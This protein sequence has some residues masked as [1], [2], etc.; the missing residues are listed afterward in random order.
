MQDTYKVAV[1]DPF[2][3]IRCV[4]H[5]SCEGVRNGPISCCHALPFTPV[6]EG[7]VGTILVNTLLGDGEQGINNGNVIPIQEFVVL[8]EVHL[9]RLQ[10]KRLCFL[11][12]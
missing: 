3:A 1:C 9:V 10:N 8:D 11:Y 6:V 5:Y 12:G 4:N 2:V 7:R